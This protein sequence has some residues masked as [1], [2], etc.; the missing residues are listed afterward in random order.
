MAQIE[1][2]LL[3]LEADTTRLRMELRRAGDQ[4]DDFEDRT[5]RRMGDYDTTMRR[6]TSSVEGAF[7]RHG[8]A[9]GATAVAVGAAVNA[10][11]K[12]GDEYTRAVG[13]ISAA[14][15]SLESAKTV[16]DDLAAV[17]TKTG[18]AMADTT[19]AFVRFGIAAKQIGATNRDV[20]RLIQTVQE[21]GVVSGA[22][23]QEMA[24]GSMQLGQALASGKLQ[25][26]EL[27]SI[28]E[29]MPKLAELLAA[30]LGVS[31]GK[32]RE[33]GKEG[34]LSA[35]RVFTAL[36]RVSDEADKLF[37]AIPQNIERASGALSS[38]W[39]RFLVKLDE[40]LGLSQGIAKEMMGAAKALDVITNA[41]QAVADQI[42]R[43]E[44]QIEGG[45]VRG[46]DAMKRLKEQL[47][48]LRMNEAEMARMDTLLENQS[49]AQRK[50][51]A[52]TEAHTKALD[53]FGKLQDDLLTPM[54]KARKAHE[55]R[56]KVIEDATAAGADAADI[57]AAT[58]DAEAALAAAVDRTAESRSKGTVEANRYV[59]AAADTLATMQLQNDV[60]QLRLG[61]QD[62]MADLLAEDAR[63]QERLGPLYAENAER[64]RELWDANR[65][66]TEQMDARTEAERQAERTRTEAFHEQQRVARDYERFADRI[67]G[68]LAGALAEACEDFP[69]D[70]LSD[71][72]TAAMIQEALQ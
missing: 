21:L 11:A 61:G 62:R 69:E 56:M 8:L 36:L 57:A 71:P 14:T 16:Y 64:L 48:L 34:E 9:I 67:A 68:D 25:G 38:S 35:D 15:G 52:E 53:A 3:R 6:I 24:A 19:G 26:D 47:D 2:I 40:G 28:L 23:T 72:E 32:L 59:D 17:S 50:A 63:W 30:E 18:A 1:D 31:I 29:N 44:G 12:A 46:P 27:R 45:R 37:A 58:A 54:E 41:P 5:R 13:K 22:S 42:A 10:I 55:A 7:R 51:R 65:G 20:V 39:D 43:I 33:M 4:V 70:A 66:L 49:E 60:L